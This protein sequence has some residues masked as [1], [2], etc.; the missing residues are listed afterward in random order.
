LQILS[1]RSP[2]LPPFTHKTASPGE[3]V[4][5]I[6]A[7]IPPVPDAARTITSWAVAKTS[8]S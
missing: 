4:F 3:S 1:Q 6:A 5:A 2:N 7:S 8:L